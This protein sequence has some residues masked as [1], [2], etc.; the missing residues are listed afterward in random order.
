[1]EIFLLYFF[2]GMVAS[3][4]GAMAGLGGGVII[5]PVLDVFGHFDLATIGVLSAA[6]VFA[7]A[8]TSLI[9]I[10]KKKFELD[11]KNSLLIAIGSII[12][13]FVGKAIFNFVILQLKLSATIGAFQSTLLAVILLCIYLFIKNKNHIKTYQVE[14]NTIIFT[15]GFVLGLLSA[16]LGIGGGP[17]NVAILTL[18][19]SMN[20][21]N[22]SFNSLFIIFF[23]QLS[24]LLLVLFTTDIREYDLSMLVYMIVGG[25]LG[26][27]VGSNLVMKYTNKTISKIF[28]ITI[29][30]VLLINIFNI[31]KFIMF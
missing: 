14:S 18:L 15:A 24:S 4:L 31:F 22:A 28:N 27:I 23:S 6:T 10:R 29:L 16:F 7:M 21:R 2:I 26:G 19:F 25:I 30:L 20:A 17:L 3:T 9:K 11:K 8:A 13:G 1:M 5:K 12:G